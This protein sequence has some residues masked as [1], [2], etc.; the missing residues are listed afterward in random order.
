MPVYRNGRPFFTTI[1][2]HQQHEWFGL[3]PGL[4]DGAVK[5]WR[6]L[7]GTYQALFYAYCIMPNHIHFLVRSGDLVSFIRR[8]NGKLTVEARVFD[9][10]R[11]FWQRSFY[12]H[13]LRTD[14]SINNI[15]CYI[16][17]NPMRA[18]LVENPADYRWSGSDV[19]LDWRNYYR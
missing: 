15:A 17:E 3:H 6:D 10:K 9:R 14:E 19:W 18:G 13:A 11:K 7:Q 5:I 1:T 12:D 16:W 2:T 8:F 4:C